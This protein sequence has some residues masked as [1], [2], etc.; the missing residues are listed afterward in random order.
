LEKSKPPFA[1]IRHETS[2]KY[3]F[4]TGITVSAHTRSRIMGKG[5][6]CHDTGR[7]T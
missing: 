5:K 6:P 7:V 2:A 4:G 3:Q 1:G